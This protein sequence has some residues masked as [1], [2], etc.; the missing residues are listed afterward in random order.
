M[1]RKFGHF[2]KSIL[3]H[4]EG[5]N[6]G[7]NKGNTQNRS[8]SSLEGYKNN[9]K[10]QGCRGFLI[11]VWILWM[12]F[13]GNRAWTKC[14][15]CLLKVNYKI[16]AKTWKKKFSEQ[17]FSDSREWGRHTIIYVIILPNILHIPYFATFLHFHIFIWHNK[18]NILCC[19]II[20]TEVAFICAHIPPYWILSLHIN[21]KWGGLTNF[22]L[23]YFWLLVFNIPHPYIR[24]VQQKLHQSNDGLFLF[25]C[26]SSPPD[27]YLAKHVLSFISVAQSHVFAYLINLFLFIWL[28]IWC[29][30]LTL[31]YLWCVLFFTY[32]S[33]GFVSRVLGIDLLLWRY[34]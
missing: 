24:T 9:Y 5:S 34:I 10:S 13:A 30:E 25:M 16:N 7:L 33:S 28:K 12:G 4:V 26:S 19:V 3:H 6:S 32:L 15:L 17:T 29:L 27:V 1:R 21:N 11:G 14:M 2:F 31:W 18:A 8:F 22:G 23:D 20:L